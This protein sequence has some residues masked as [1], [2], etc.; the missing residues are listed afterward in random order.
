ME[1]EVNYLAVVLAALSTM[2]VGSL[3]YSPKGFGTLWQKLSKAKMNEKPTGSEMLKLY[4]GAVLASTLTA[5]I[6]AHVAYMSSSVLGSD[7]LQSA[8]STAFWLWLGFT[9]AR[10]YVHDSFEGRPPKLTLITVSHELVTFMVMA[11]I[12]GLMGV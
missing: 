12:I 8:L 1:I 5:Y 7:F 10:V 9:A 11:L 6:L 4:G 3:W 2:V